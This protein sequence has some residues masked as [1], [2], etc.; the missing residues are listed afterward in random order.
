MNAVELIS[1][2]E[3]ILARDLTAIDMRNPDRPVLRLTQYA[4][5]ALRMQATGPEPQ[6]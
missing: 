6:Q 4:L 3:D 1:H 2:A 5:E